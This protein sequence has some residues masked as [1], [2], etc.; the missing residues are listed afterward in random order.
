MACHRQPAGQRRQA[1][2]KASMT[3]QMPYEPL[4]ASVLFG[5]HCGSFYLFKPWNRLNRF[6][7]PKNADVSVGFSQ[8]MPLGLIKL[9]VASVAD[10]M[11]SVL[12]ANHAGDF[13]QEESCSPGLPDRAGCLVDLNGKLHLQSVASSNSNL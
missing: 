2:A 6:R 10:F 1:L 11:L 5:L 13:V 3:G 8:L 9:D 4:P 12:E 7:Y